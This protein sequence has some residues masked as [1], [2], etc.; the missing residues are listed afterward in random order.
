MNRR[1]FLITFFLSLFASLCLMPSAQAQ[2]FRA[3]LSSTGNDANPCTLQAPCRL[4]PAALNAVIDK[5]E[6]WMLDSANYNTAMVSVTKNVSIL[7]VPGVVGSLVS[8][9]G[10]GLGCPDTQ[11]M[12]IRGAVT[13]KLRN[14]VFGRNEL[15][16][17]TESID[18]RNGPATL[19]VEDTLFNGTSAGINAD[20][21]KVSVRNSVF[22]DCSFGVNVWNNTQVD[23]SGS[24]IINAQTAISASG[25]VGGATVRVGVTDT[26]ITGATNTGLLA[27]TFT[28]NSTARIDAIRTTI[29]NSFQAALAQNDASG[30]TAVISF[31]YGMVVGNTFGLR[32]GGTVPIGA[33]METTGNN[34]VRD[35][36]ADTT[37]SVTTFSMM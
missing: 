34:L 9:A 12:Q 21:A 10:C 23:I 5:G 4:L 15:N 1:G 13:V 8:T 36:G 22:R 3:Y 37:G 19:E 35:N 27:Y 26:V 30:G 31:G 28:A 24:K 32:Q 11:A 29:S 33:T 18:V 7:A 6:V 20:A 25:Q 14:L 2:L 16:P 17:G